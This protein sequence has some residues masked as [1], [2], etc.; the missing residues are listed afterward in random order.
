MKVFAKAAVAILLL[1]AASE[2]A[3][4]SAPYPGS[5]AITDVTFNSSTSR[6]EAPGSDNWAITWSNDNHQYATWGDG[7]G[8]GGTNSN[9]RVSL[10]YARVEGGS[11]GY[12]GYNVWGGF[13]AENPAQFGGKSY[14]I[15][16]IGGTLYSWAGPGSGTTSYSEA[17]LYRSTNK[18]ATWTG[19]SWK[20]V[21]ADGVIMP[22][23]LNFG[24]DYAGA[25]DNYVY[26]YFINMKAPSG[27]LQVHKPGEIFLVRVDKSRI[28][29]SKSDYQWF[30][31]TSS[32]PSWSS[33]FSSKKPVFND[34]NG[35]GWCMSVSYNAGLKRYILCTEHTQTIKGNLGIFEAPEPWGP[36]KTVKYTSNWRGTG[37]TF[38]WNFSNKWM[39]A[40]GKNFT[41]IYTGTGA[42][43]SWN[44]LQG[45]F[46][47]STSSNN[48]PSVNVT[49]PTAGQTF[50]APANITISATASDSDGSVLQ[51][52]FR[53]GGSIVGTDTTSPYSFSWNNV[54]A[55]SYT[56]TARATDNQGATTTSSGVNI[57]VNAPVNQS[58]SPQ[59]SSPSSDGQSWPQGATLSFTGSASDPEDGNLTGNSLIWWIDRIGDS[60][61]AAQLSSTGTSGSQVLSGSIGNVQLDVVGSNY[62]LILRATDS[63]GATAEAK[64]RYSV[65]APPPQ[66][67]AAPSSLSVSA[68]SSSQ[69]DLSWTDN[70]SNESDF[71]IERKTGAGGT[72]SQIDIVGANT[73]SYSDSSVAPSTTYFYRVRA[74]NSAGPSGYSNED[75]DTT[76][77]APPGGS[78]LISNL[79]PSSYGTDVLDVGKFQ[80]V[81]RTYTFSGV[82]NPL[83][84]LDYILTANGDKSSQGTGWVTFT[85][86][87]DVTVYIAHDDRI[88]PKPTWMLGYVD[89]GDDLLSAGG[90]TFSV[91]AKDYLQ[92][93]VT[94]GGNI[95]SGT[96][97]NSMYTVVVG[98]ATGSGTTDTDGDGLTDVDETN[99]YGTNPQMAD[100]DGDGTDDGTEVAQGTDPLDPLSYPGAPGPGPGPAG[101]SSGSNG[102]CGATGAE[103]LLLLGLLFLR[104]R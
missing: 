74:T 83:L 73:T 13:N 68:V 96:T 36:W 45:S 8:F 17:R 47:T 3:A 76:P 82:P 65:T 27:G 91:W 43:D 92:G 85:V 56:L 50:T 93:T 10:G 84:N 19:A 94:L 34:S 87:Q 77:A 24:K 64:R 60:L 58:P 81:D 53:V 100:T 38:F 48:P 5:S 66:P 20:Y 31:G 99:L 70:A 41:L 23:I 89:T 2:L 98:P 51:V 22:T 79:S 35:V 59:I 46:T 78:G 75:S 15:I 102:G 69:V 95:E 97:G 28:F 12:K 55:G 62:D 26:H 71:Q 40:D 33:S 6:R 9:G 30:S 72:Y 11:P 21:K 37:T 52:E 32:S 44:T 63:Q 29:G 90:G 57:T 14:G 4:Q 7:G 18:G 67:P 16:S 101:K 25:R 54:A 104:R 80:Y 49:Q 88:T 86:S 103:V 39:S 61:A 1:S 42:Y